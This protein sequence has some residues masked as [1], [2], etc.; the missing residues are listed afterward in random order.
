MKDCNF[1]NKR[2]EDLSGD[3]KKIDNF[4]KANQRKNIIKNHL[5]VYKTLNNKNEEVWIE[6]NLAPILDKNGKIAF[7]LNVYRDIT[8]QKEKEIEIEL[9]K[10]NYQKQACKHT[11]QHRSR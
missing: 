6:N 8:T 10:Q 1:F 3:F 9:Q 11:F 2:T 5:Y 7:Y 4:L